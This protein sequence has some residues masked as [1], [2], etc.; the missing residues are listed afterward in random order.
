MEYMTE[1]RLF[2]SPEYEERK[3]WLVEKYQRKM[4]RAGRCMRDTLDCQRYVMVFK[5]EIGQEIITLDPR[6]YAHFNR[7][8]VAI[9][10]AR[11]DEISGQIE[12]VR[13]VVAITPC[14]R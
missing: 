10:T 9:V 3:M 1:K 8:D 12:P 11:C 7:G 13:T 14:R 2:K 5:D 4:L 6:F